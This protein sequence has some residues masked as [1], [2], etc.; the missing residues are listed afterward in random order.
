MLH[1][2]SSLLYPPSTVEKS[3]TG[4]VS[5]P[6][7]H[8]SSVTELGILSDTHGYLHPELLDVLEGVDRILHAGDIG[9]LSILDALE[10]VAPV[11]AVFG[12]VDGWDIRHRTDEHQ[13]LTVEG[14]NVWMTHIAGRPGA[15]QQGMGQKLADDPPDILVCGHSH[16]LRVERVEALGNMLHVN[17]GAAGR[18]GFH[19][20]KT[21]LRLLVDGGTARSVDVIHLDA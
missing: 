7:D 13:R 8:E 6:A 12:N 19:Q 17:P 1:P 5:F 9:D 18:Q 14:L 11:A 2:L 21:C 16:I 20:K 3:A 10:T 15:W 4:S